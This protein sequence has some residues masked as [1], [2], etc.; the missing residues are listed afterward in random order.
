MA[1]GTLAPMS[2]PNARAAASATPFPHRPMPYVAHLWHQ[3]GTLGYLLVILVIDV[4]QTTSNRELTSA[5]LAAP[6]PF[7][8][9]HE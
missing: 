2:S 8:L 6:L 5:Y 4:G 3:L 1:E 9:P 7:R